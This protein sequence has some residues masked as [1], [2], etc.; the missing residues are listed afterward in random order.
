MVPSLLARAGQQ[1][2]V[3]VVVAS[4]PV[5]LVAAGVGLVVAAFQAASQLQDPTLAHLP[6]LLA[7]S[8]AVALLGPWMGHEIAQFAARMLVAAP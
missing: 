3:L 2:L 7:V 4:L 8:A 5:L 1:A 6:R